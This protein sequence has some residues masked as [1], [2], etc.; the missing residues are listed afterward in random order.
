M[1]DRP[2]TSSTPGTRPGLAGPWEPHALNPIKSDCRSARPGGRV[3]ELDGR[4]IRPAQRCE[5]AYGEALAWL[6]IKRL[7]PDSFAEEEI[8]LWRADGPGLSGPHGADLSTG[9][10]AV[11]FRSP[12][13]ARFSG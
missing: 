4:L 11:D 5:E 3:L 9:L 10:R 6:E 8:A 7:T 2:G 13:A 12:M 1:E